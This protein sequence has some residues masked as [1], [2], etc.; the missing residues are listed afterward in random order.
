MAPIRRKTAYNVY[1]TE[2]VTAGPLLITAIDSGQLI[3]TVIDNNS[4]ET[5]RQHCSSAAPVHHRPLV[6][7]R[8]FE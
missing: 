4:P 3:T 2:K 5:A 8:S 1:T 7:V 6:H